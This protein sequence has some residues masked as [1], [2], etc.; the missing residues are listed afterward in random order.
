MA[1]ATE[2]EQLK[3]N[4]LLEKVEQRTTEST[5]K[6]DAL[7]EAVKQPSEYEKIAEDVAKDT[8]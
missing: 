1:G 4:Q 3:T 8:K 2:Q 6:L 5:G 7:I